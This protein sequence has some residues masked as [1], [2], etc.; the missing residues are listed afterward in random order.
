MFSLKQIGLPK[1]LRPPNLMLNYKYKSFFMQEHRNESSQSQD[2]TPKKLLF[3]DTTK[4]NE[5]QKLEEELMTTRIREVETLTEL[6]E[7]RLKASFFMIR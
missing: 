7:L 4:S 3:W 1:L 5:T 2:L 6:K